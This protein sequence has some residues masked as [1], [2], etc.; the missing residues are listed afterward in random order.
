MPLGTTPRPESDPRIPSQRYPDNPGPD[1][2]AQMD[3]AAGPF[4][5][6]HHNV[7]PFKPNDVVSA[8]ELG[9]HAQ[10]ERMLRAGSMSVAAPEHADEYRA[11][12]RA[13]PPRAES[14]PPPSPP[15]PP[16]PAQPPAPAP[17]QAPASPPPPA[18]DQGA[19]AGGPEK[20]AGFGQPPKGPEKK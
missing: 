17:A 16:P 12:L 3:D 18:P 14:A 19:Q 1:D 2:H 15:P 13:Q 7:G 11:Q 6:L 10:I 5:F 8:R 20:A 9:P 4:F